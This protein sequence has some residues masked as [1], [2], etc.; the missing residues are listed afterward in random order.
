MLAAA[1]A[2]GLHDCTELM[3]PVTT[4]E[5]NEPACSLLTVLV[6]MT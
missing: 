2:L 6:M 4:T 3:P 1:V 5:T